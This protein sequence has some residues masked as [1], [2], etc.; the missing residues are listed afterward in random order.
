MASTSEVDARNTRLLRRNARRADTPSTWVLTID[1]S[2]VRAWRW[3]ALNRL[4][5]SNMTSRT[6]ASA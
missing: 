1:S 5:W 2:W 4:L 6:T 3:P